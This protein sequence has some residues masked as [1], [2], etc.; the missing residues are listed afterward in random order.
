MYARNKIN[1][2][3]NV[4]PR[5]SWVPRVLDHKPVFQWFLWNLPIFGLIL[6]LKK[7]Q[8]WNWKLPLVKWCSGDLLSVNYQI[9]QCHYLQMYV[10]GGW[11][12]HVYPKTPG[13]GAISASRRH[14]VMKNYAETYN[15]NLLSILY[16]LQELNLHPTIIIHLLKFIWIN[17]NVPRVRIYV[18]ATKTQKFSFWG[19]LGHKLEIRHFCLLSA[20]N[21]HFR[22]KIQILVFICAEHISF[23]HFEH[24]NAIHFHN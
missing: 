6:I 18:V 23:C 7:F 16:A 14:Q 17:E 21:V 1:I 8:R 11:I 15:F 22:N 20:R 19:H 10:W 4:V 24:K 2:S 12:W 5:P 3:N 13:F 9:K